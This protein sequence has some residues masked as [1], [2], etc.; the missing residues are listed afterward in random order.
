MAIKK[1]EASLTEYRHNVLIGFPW[2]FQTKNVPAS[3]ACPHGEGASSRRFLP[4]SVMFYG[5]DGEELD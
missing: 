1:I 3:D 4:H 2:R 5:P